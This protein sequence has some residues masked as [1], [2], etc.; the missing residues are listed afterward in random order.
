MIASLPGRYVWADSGCR[1]RQGHGVVFPH[2]R[3]G[4]MVGIGGGILSRRTRLMYGW[5]ISSSASRRVGMAASPSMTPARLHG[6]WRIR[7][8]GF[9]RCS[10]CCLAECGHKA[11]GTARAA[12]TQSP[13][14][15]CR[16]CSPRTYGWQGHE[17]AAPSYAYQGRKHDRLFR[18]EYAPRR[19]QEL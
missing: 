15:S 7:A 12:R 6:G 19:R 11:Q 8:E 17:P 1:G 4:L 9:P 2:I 16:I 13:R 10:T 3:A 18:P 5:A 14:D